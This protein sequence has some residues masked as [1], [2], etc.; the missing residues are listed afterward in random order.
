[1]VHGV[2]ALRRRVERDRSALLGAL[3][4]AAEPLPH[5][6][7][8]VRRILEAPEIRHLIADGVGL[9]KTVQT[10]MILNVLRLANPDHRTILVAPD[11]LLEQWTREVTVRGHVRPCFVHTAEAGSENASIFLVKPSDL[12]DETSLLRDARDFF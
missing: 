2:Q 4:V 11:H 3:G 9:G 7:A 1:M 10:L 6:L 5:Q 8:N 12:L